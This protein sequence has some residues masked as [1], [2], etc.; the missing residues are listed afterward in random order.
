M[1]SYIS[2]EQSDKNKVKIR[3]KNSYIAVYLGSFNYYKAPDRI[4]DL[5]Y[6]TS[7]AKL[8]IKYFIYGEENIKKKIN[9]NEVDS[10]FLMRNIK[11]LGLEKIVKI[12]GKTKNPKKVLLNTDIL[13]RPSRRNDNWGRDIIEAMSTGKFIIST[14]NDNF[15]LTNKLNG[16]VVNS[17]NAVELKN[18]I[19][20]YINNIDKFNN[21]KL[22][23]YNFALKNFNAKNNS[24]CAKKFFLDIFI[25]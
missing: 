7:K 13:I 17:W 18:T 21:I 12:K 2:Y 24:K 3:K 16:I 25:S 1:K 23:A 15:F 4:I 20:G 14:G 8:P 6:E 10:A 11:K 22:N 9:K 5:A 19:K